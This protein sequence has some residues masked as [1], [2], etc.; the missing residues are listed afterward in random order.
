MLKYEI[1]KK[2]K[3]LFTFE[4]LKIYLLLSKY[5]FICKINSAQRVVI[6]LEAQKGGRVCPSVRFCYLY[7]FHQWKFFTA[8]SGL[9][10][11]I[12][13]SIRVYYVKGKNEDQLLCINL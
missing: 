2:K 7:G 11:F 6:V 8:F 4:K 5:T 10:L 13:R 3:K 12:L 1:P 9:D